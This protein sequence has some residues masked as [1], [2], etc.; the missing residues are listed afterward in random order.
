MTPTPEVGVKPDNGTAVRPEVR[1][2][3]QLIDA[4]VTKERVDVFFG[5]PGGAISP[6]HDAVAR[7][8]DVRVINVRHEADAVFA[9]AG[10]ARVT[11][12]LGVAFVTS[13]PGV[14]NT[15][16]ALASAYMEGLP[17]LVLAGD[18]AR[19]QHGKGALQ[20][21]SS[22]G[23]DICH[24]A[25][26]ITKIATELV[27]PHSVVPQ[28]FSAIA[29]MRRGR[30]GPGLI[31]CPVDVV[32]AR[33]PRPSVSMPRE[34]GPT[35]EEHGLDR[36][37]E[38]LE[39]AARP[40][41]LI[42]NGVRTGD[43]P[44]ALRALAERLQVPV[45]TTPHAK[46]VF[47]ESHALALGVYGLAMHPSAVAFLE[48]GFDCMLAV[49]T[50]FSELA[51]NGWNKLLKPTGERASMIQIDVDPLRIGRAY[52][53]DLAIV[54]E[55]APALRSIAN[56]LTQRPTRVYGVERKSNPAAFPVGPQHKMTPQRAI[57]ELQRTM[58][59]DTRFTIDIG[60]HTLYALHYLEIDDPRACTVALGLG[61]MGTGIGAA[62]GIA[63]APG[64]HPVAAIAGDGGFLMSLSAI[65]AAAAA[66]LPIVFAILNDGRY[67]MC[68]IGYEAIYGKTPD[69]GMGSVDLVQAARG[70]GAQ[71]V[72]ITE[73]DQLRGLDL[74][75]MRA[76][77]TVVLDIH[78]DSDVRMFTNVR[79]EIIQTRPET[80]VLK[81]VRN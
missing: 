67:G 26:P 25:R 54:G 81:L 61:S 53:V 12:K 33:A 80:P 79:H 21:G 74:E 19:A 5:L 60:E 39:A 41:L 72:R 3:D 49:G 23:L 38:L 16:N 63:T 73:P 30:P 45:I 65:A 70:V 35:L 40:V 13:G 8:D 58:P 28:L 22:H 56:R 52:P 57:W 47:P 9:A 24:L 17:V 71:A 37:A 20:D 43:G 59:A 36:A 31:S 48:E 78:I 42:G 76:A 10:Y 15:I 18:A 62:L 55:A 46:G 4:L 75:A 27:D 11:G 51:T 14:L 29:A 50:S 66:K 69:F 6:L 34:L 7:R 32:R 77:G 44:A 64:N 1:A 2:A 68:D